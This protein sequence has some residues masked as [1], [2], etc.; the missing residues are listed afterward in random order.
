MFLLWATPFGLQRMYSFTFSILYPFALFFAHSSHNI[1]SLFIFII[2]F[3]I[4]VEFRLMLLPVRF[5]LRTEHSFV[6]FNAVK[7]SV[8]DDKDNK[9]PSHTHR[10]IE[11]MKYRVNE[12]ASSKKKTEVVAKWTAKKWKAERH[13]HSE[14]REIKAMQRKRNEEKKGKRICGFEERNDGGMCKKIYGL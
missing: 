6:Q 9:L 13:W 3:F 12:R 11:K 5:A 14:L 10:K 4:S 8:D 2:V 7:W 1:V